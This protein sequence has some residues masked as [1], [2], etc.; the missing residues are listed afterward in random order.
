[1]QRDIDRIIASIK[2]QIPDVHV[3]QLQKTHPADDDGLWWFCVPGRKNIQ[4]E[5]STGNCPFLI[6]TDLSSE[7]I[8][9]LEETIHSLKVKLQT[10]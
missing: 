5:S 8:E 4:V 9:T 6:E 2:E 1:M 3:E 10:K 7:T